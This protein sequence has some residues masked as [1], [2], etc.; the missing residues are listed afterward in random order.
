MTKERLIAFAV[1]MM[2]GLQGCADDITPAEILEKAEAAYESMDTYKAKGTTVSD[3][4]TGGMKVKMDTTFSMILKKPNLYLISWSQNNSAMPSA[5]QS[6]AV[7][8]DGTQPFLY[9]ES[10]NAYSKMDGDDVALGGATG[11]SGGAAFTIPALFLSAFKDQ[12]APFSRLQDPQIE[13]TEK[14][15]GEDCYVIGGPSSISKKETFWISKKGYLIRKYY[16]SLE[17]PEGGVA[18]PE[19]TDEQVD[20]AIKSMGQEVTEES[21]KNIRQMMESSKAMLKNVKMTG[22]STELH[23]EV[24]SPQL[25]KSDF[26][27]AVPEGA[28]LKESLFGGVPDR[29]N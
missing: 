1:L 3:V 16:R 24:S 13:M 18:I 28:T 29:G 21:R 14:V 27:F 7:W 8:S 9:M 25:N 6:G 19:M 5:S 23:A 17:Q 10:M 2:L 22:S 20:T 4:D 11:I 12:P 26:T 15:E